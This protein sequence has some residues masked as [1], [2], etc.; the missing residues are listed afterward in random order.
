[1][2]LNDPFFDAWVRDMLRQAEA[3][4]P[5]HLWD[6]I[7]RDS[8][9]YV[10][11]ERHKYLLVLLL[12][13]LVTGSLAWW[14]IHPLVRETDDLNRVAVAKREASA[15]AGRPVLS[16]HRAAMEEGRLTPPDGAR[17]GA[18]GAMSERGTM[19]AD[20][21]MP[22][23]GALVANGAAPVGGAAS[24]VGA[25]S[26]SGAMAVDA[27]AA[28]NDAVNSAAAPPTSDATQLS[29]ATL[30]SDA[31]PAGLKPAPVGSV[32]ALN[33]ETSPLR[34]NARPIL[35]LQHKKHTYLE[36]YAGPDHSTH[37]ITAA[38][39]Q[40]KNF[41]QQTKGSVTPYPS[42][43]MG[44]NV[45]LPLFS[46]YW[47]IRTGLHFFQINEQLHYYN[48][49]ATKTV[50]QVTTRSVTQPSGQVVLVSDTTHVT[51]K[52]TYVKQSLNA[53]R[54]VDVPVIVSRVLVGNPQF[55]LEG[56]AGTLLNLAS[57][58]TGDILDTT[59][60]PA[61]LHRGAAHT[62]STWKKNIGASLYGSLSI[63]DQLTSRIQISLEPY[64]RYELGTIN[65]DV[66]VYKERFV[67]T[68]LALGLRY[69][70]GR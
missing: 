31:L 33:P 30:A 66:T 21:A 57:W 64:I 18:N 9:F 46:D 7:R 59:G 8:S 55:Q 34:S 35:S 37:Y 61:A 11:K 41:V 63:H 20:G 51:Y 3:R 12:L 58:Y 13:L 26:T 43:S 23:K 36:L 32:L 10:V 68:G 54:G 2:S 50:N 44:V 6:A 60:E 52:G 29:N 25:M 47:R 16:G 4:P 38:N 70:L 67:T 69:A 28:T 40:Y 27:T 62:A 19:P 5:E 39:P 1:M 49:S 42:F 48:P 56:S 53:Y 65:Q 22:S 14:G 45:D 24:A 15:P 17:A